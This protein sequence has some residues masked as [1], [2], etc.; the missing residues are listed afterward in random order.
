MKKK[1][2]PR[3]IHP[4]DFKTTAGQSISYIEPKVGTILIYPMVQHIGAPCKPTVA[5][6][7]YV[8]LGQVIGD[9]DAFVSAPIHATVSG[10]VVNISEALTPR[11]QLCEAVFIEND[12]QFAPCI[13][14]QPLKDYKDASKEDILSKIR[15]GGVVG[16][17]GAGFPA[18]VK[19]NPPK[20]K[21]IDTIIVNAA[22]CEPYL[23]TDHRV[24]LE[25]T[26]QMLE[27]LRIVLH[28]FPEACGI[29]AIEDNKPDVIEKLK[30]LD[31]GANI[32]VMPLVTKYPQGGEKQLIYTSTGREVPSGGLPMDVGC[33][34]HNVD[35]LVAIHRAVVIGQP[36]MRKVVTITGGAIKNPGNYQVLLGMTFKDLID[37]TGGMKS[38]PCKIVVGGPMMGVAQSKL[39]VPVIKISGGII[40]MTEEE[41][42]R[43]SKRN[44]FRCGKCVDHC[45]IGLMPLDLSAYASRDDKMNFKKYNGM[46]CTSCACCS[47]VCPAHRNVAGEIIKL[48]DT[49]LSEK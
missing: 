16:L 45:P 29:I 19:L 44:C 47:Y 15:G 1:T 9:S 7:D 32:S 33:I 46:D 31:L 27:G 23:T 21:K 20:D 30:Q 34:V 18:H 5:V 25:E 37:E 28:L 38:K 43:P 49:I 36:L 26:V 11:G 13:S 17:G 40:L 14:M 2:F 6:G 35:T 39:E 3:G 4:P 48:K 24:L 12:G 10:K 8:K 41:A 42:K 22:E